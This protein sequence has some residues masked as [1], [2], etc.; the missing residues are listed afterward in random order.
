MAVRLCL[1]ILACVSLVS[2]AAFAADKPIRVLVVTGGHG[3]EEPQFREMWKS[4]AGIDAV[5]LDQ[6]DG[7]AFSDVSAW[8]Y[9]VIVLYN[10]NQKMPEKEGAN[11]VSL[12]EK[13]VGLVIMH[14]AVAAY[15]DWPEYR[16]ILGG[17]YYLKDE[18]EGGVK[19]A[20][21]QW[22]EGVDI[23]AR[24]VPGHPVTEGV[25]K[26]V[27]N[28][29]TYKGYS[30]DEGNQILL[31]SDTSGSQKEIGWAREYR[32]ARVFFIQLGH[33]HDAYENANY[34]KLVSQAIAWTVRR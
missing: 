7:A 16:K 33:G 4:L 3:F 6:K 30:V 2:V 14:H 20:R 12:L 28:D 23:E 22:K 1:S 11:L 15:P 24:P 17:R 13:G 25:P 19:H 26:F 27:V 34:R 10:F 8:P 18:E 21:C 9:D 32:N 31:T 29:E 5:L